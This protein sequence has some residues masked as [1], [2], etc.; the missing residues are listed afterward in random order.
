MQLNMFKLFGLTRGLS[1]V[2]T[3]TYHI[4]VRKFG[5]AMGAELEPFFSGV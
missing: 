3:I 1:A 4:A 2:F 5:D